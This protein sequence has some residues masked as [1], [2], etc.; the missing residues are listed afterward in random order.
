M[1]KLI[2]AADDFGQSEAIDD[3]IVALIESGRISAASCLTASPRWPRAA[4]RFDRDIRAKADIGVHLDLTEFVRPAGG[5]VTLL[6][7]SLAGALD[8]GRLRALVDDQLQRFEDAMGAAPD[9][10]DGH[11][12]VHQ[13]PRVREALLSA[14]AARYGD[15]LPWIRVSVAAKRAGLKAGIVSALGG[16]ELS[17]RC[18]ALGLVCSERLL[19]F[20]DMGRVQQ[21]YRLRLRQWLEQARTGDVLMCHPAARADRSDPIGAA[22]HAE[23]VALDSAWWTEARATAGV[24]LTRGNVLAGRVASDAMQAR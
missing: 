18:R 12:H 6:L 2:V 24:E 16:G 11:R 14:L 22:R 17:A 4:C 21:D 20:Y 10:V 9:Y 23:F 19:G 1:E 3:G 7:A 13:L 15:R 5:H 8:P